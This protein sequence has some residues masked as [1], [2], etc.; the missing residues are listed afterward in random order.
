MSMNRRQ[1]LQASGALG[2]GL[3]LAFYLP[4][5]LA[6][7]LRKLGSPQNGGL[8]E[9]NA[10]IRI[11]ADSRVT[12]IVK[13]LEMGQGVYTGLPTIVAE[14]LDADWQQIRV[15]GAPAN[16]VLY[17]NLRWGPVQGTGQSTAVAN[18]YD[19]LRQA[20][21]TAR[22][23]LVEAAS[24]QW[25]VPAQEITVSRGLVQHANGR[26]ASFGELAEFAATL[27]VPENVTL[28]S[29][30]D[31][32][33]IGKRNRVERTDLQAKITGQVIYTIDVAKP[34]MLT[35]LVAHPPCLGA[36]VKSFRDSRTRA[37]T[38]VVDVVRIPTGIAV[39]ATGFWAAKKGRDA[40][41]IEWD[42]SRASRLDTDALLQHYRELARRP[43][44]V[45]RSE[46][47]PVE[48]LDGSARKVSA[49]FEVPYL[50]HAAMEP[51]DCAMEITP[52]GCQLWH[53]EQFQT[54]TQ[55]KVAQVLGL[56]P[57]QI[58][59]DMLYAGGSFG[60]RGNPRADYQ[61][62][63]AAILKAIDGRTPV[64]LMWTREDDMRGGYYRP[65]CV[66]AIEAALD[67]TGFP[68]AWHH[69]IVGQS[70]L[71]GTPLESVLLQNGIDP[72]CV[73]GA[74][75]M[76]YRIPN[77]LLD[78]HTPQLE[79]PVMWWR[80]VGHSH[81]A[82]AIEIFI[83]ELAEAAHIDPVEYRRRL[84]TDHPRLLGVMNLA[85]DKSGWG[86]RLPEGH[87]RGI[88]VHQSFG[89]FAAQVVEVAV[90]DKGEL[91]IV[92]VTCAVD[93]GTTINPHIVEAQMQGG[94]GFALTAALKGAITLKNGRIEQ[95][96]FDDYP[97]L[98]MNEMP[99]VDV[100]IVASTEPPTGV[101]EP[102]VPP[103]APA[104]CNA[105]YQATGQRIRT[106][107]IRQPLLKKSS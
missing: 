25:Q 75:D 92:R 53:G 61:A 94:I 91:E 36:T 12:V 99:P 3:T 104:L 71:A 2:A 5:A 107:P 82:F 79:V 97:I 6:G 16:A 41:E 29:A 103:L 64:K 4:P 49:V 14:E 30:Q 101:G 57:D 11:A 100:H 67:T 62:E 10:F 106:L 54:L 38:G 32:Q 56:K 86:A 40:L 34:G 28:K 1:F 70:I 8:F 43:G 17:K 63:A 42:E 48:V 55:L 47:N 23:M 73:E 98:R 84:L 52:Q 65:L 81:T 18:S 76:P 95:S 66:H 90:S 19:Q 37:V 93:C 35:V 13:H 96:N 77:V 88:A 87:G 45:A 26:K 83:D 9:P 80:S 46:G 21:A 31:F 85:A 69:R 24:R 7:N 72:M 22:A 78:I 15:E 39:L 50:A 20:G 89:T 68:T 105:L 60:R 44:T 58:A 102:G 59:I 27:P 51:L 33:L 74:R